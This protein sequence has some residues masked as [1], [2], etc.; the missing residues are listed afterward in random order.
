MERGTM[1]SNVIDEKQL[2][3]AIAALRIGQTH[4]IEAQAKRPGDVDL[5]GIWTQ[6]E[7]ALE[8]LGCDD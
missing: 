1:N 4:V 8:V 7:R 6:I 3:L 5:E 2:Q